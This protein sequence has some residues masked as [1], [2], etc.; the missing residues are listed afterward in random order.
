M[1]IGGLRINDVKK[2]LSTTFYE[3]LKRV[4]F[5]KLR[6]ITCKEYTFQ[7]GL[8]VR[9]IVRYVRSCFVT[10]LNMNVM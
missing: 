2:L 8:M 7:V 6:V 5:N 3:T 10:N 9:L 4:D 1:E